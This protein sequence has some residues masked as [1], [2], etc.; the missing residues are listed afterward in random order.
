MI[1]KPLVP[2]L[3]TLLVGANAAGATDLDL[4]T[5]GASGFIGAALFLQSDPQPAGT[6]VIDPFVRMSTNSDSEQ[7]FNTDHS[8]LDGDLVDVKPGL[9]THSLLVGAL[10]PVLLDGVLY[11]RFLLDINQTSAN[12]LLSL[13]ELRIYTSADPALSSNAALFAENLVYDMGA[14]NRVLLDYSLNSGSGSGDMFLYV[15]AAAFDGLDNQYLY[16]YSKFGASGGDYATNDGYEEW[17]HIMSTVSVENQ[18]WSAVK[19]LY[20]P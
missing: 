5:A 4:T 19:E 7:G 6:G 12:P 9:W 8:P 18:S 17:A 10:Q 13:D 14:G 11:M 1:Q 3:L 16:L 2:M 20:R 15:P